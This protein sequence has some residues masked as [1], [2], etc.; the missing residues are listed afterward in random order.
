MADGEVHPLLVVRCLVTPLALTLRQPGATAVT[1]VE[2]WGPCLYV[3]ALSGPAWLGRIHT[4]N[5][6]HSPF[7][8]CTAPKL[9]NC[10]WLGTRP[11]HNTSPLPSRRSHQWAK[12]RDIPG[13]VDLL[14]LA[15]PQPPV[16]TDST[17]RESQSARV[18]AL[19]SCTDVWLRRENGVT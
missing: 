15:R 11:Q 17:T 19:G 16:G 8:V 6:C 1:V 12:A 9:E 13:L 3:G 10:V 7:D 5:S 14:G 2:G 4:G 18:A